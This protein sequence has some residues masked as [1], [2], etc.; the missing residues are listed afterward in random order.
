MWLSDISPAENF[1]DF[2]FKVLEETQNTF[3]IDYM[4]TNHLL[5]SQAP[6]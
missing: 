5:H 1:S 6:C 2:E 4:F 3:L